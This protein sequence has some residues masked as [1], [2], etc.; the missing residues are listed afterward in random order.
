[1]KFIAIYFDNLFVVKNTVNKG[2]NMSLSMSPKGVTAPTVV[3]SP[4]EKTQVDETLSSI[5]EFRD[6]EGTVTL[7]T[8][9]LT[10]TLSLSNPI[11][12]GQYGSVYLGKCTST[13]GKENRT[14][15]VKYSEE[16]PHS[17]P[18]EA[19][20]KLGVLV[21][22]VI[23]DHQTPYVAIMEKDVDL[24]TFL[25]HFKRG[26]LTEF[27]ET[28]IL[29]NLLLCFSNSA[30][31]LDLIHG[32][33]FIH[34]DVKPENMGR[35][36]IL[37]TQNLSEVGSTGFPHTPITASPTTMCSVRKAT[38]AVD[39]SQL[40]HSLKRLLTVFSEAAL[41]KFSPERMDALIG[42]ARRKIEDRLSIDEVRSELKA[43]R[44]DY[45]TKHCRLFPVFFD[46][47]TQG[48]NRKIEEKLTGLGTL[49]QEASKSTHFGA[50]QGKR[51]VE[52][53]KDEGTGSK[54]AKNRG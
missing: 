35:N 46:S 24:I 10:T 28:D 31:D 50:Q 23:K 12:A 21:L 54:R 30:K 2:K 36:H 19:L 40:L 52:D 41:D 37:D 45:L 22:G 42:T 8:S 39:V 13:S 20:H 44:V 34:G 48:L 49:K 9:Q 11:G 14:V 7:T 15:A 1:V 26:D 32:F 47:H 16:P 6:P 3:V 18:P 33:E 5:K 27:Q 53:L 29:D 4:R 17:L 51:F 25:D 38:P 43:I